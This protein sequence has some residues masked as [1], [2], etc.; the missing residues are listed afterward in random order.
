VLR[1]VSQCPEHYPRRA[2]I[3]AKRPLFSKRH[4]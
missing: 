2:G 3:P 4:G 1:Q